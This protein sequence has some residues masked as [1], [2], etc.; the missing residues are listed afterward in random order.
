M[1]TATAGWPASSVRLALFVLRGVFISLGLFALLRIGVVETHV[2]LPMTLAQAALAIRLFGA[3]ALPIGVTLACSGADALS[4]CMGAVLAYPASW[5]DR[6]VGAA[7]AIALV[8]A[9]NIL[10]IGT[11]GRAAAS[12]F[13]FSALHLYIWPLAIT[14]AIGAYVLGWMRA[15]NATA[16]SVTVAAEA[17]PALSR[18]FIGFA[19]LFL[20]AFVAAAPLYLNSAAVLAVAAFVAQ[21]AAAILNAAGVQSHAVANTL[22]MSHGGFVVTEECVSTPL[23]PLYLAGVV[24]FAPDWRRRAIGLAAAAPIFVALGVVRLLVVAV[25]SSVA[26]QSFFIHAFYQLLAGVSIIAG[27]A[28]WRHRNRTAFAWAVSGIGVGA[29][30]IAAAGPVYERLVT[31]VVAL[32]IAD[33][34]GAI[35]F[36]PVFQ[37]ALYFGLWTAA[38]IHAGW[39]RL[40]VGL[41]ALVASQVLGLAALNAVLNHTSMTMAVRDVRGWALAAPVLVFAAMVSLGRTK[42]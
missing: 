8:L 6:A 17:A 13:W 22:W 16:R 37:T 39:K 38:Y 25:P 4:L 21:A 12:P 34:Q 14:L 5:R 15:S 40:L 24:A 27:A 1:L 41:A 29:L 3:P 42:R 32:P 11:L 31:S 7:G 35:A 19:G 10:R 18:R 36:L 2:M 28:F 33:P 23:I 9:L 26:T 20:L 30:F